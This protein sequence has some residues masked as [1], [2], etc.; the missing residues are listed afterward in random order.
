MLNNLQ[1][2]CQN[3]IFAYYKFLIYLFHEK[4]QRQSFESQV[5]K[6]INDDY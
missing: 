5:V 4:I 3:Y 6:F 1:G 2:L